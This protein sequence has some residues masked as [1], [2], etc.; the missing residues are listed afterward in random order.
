MAARSFR[1]HFVT[2]SDGRL[3]GILLRRWDRFFDKPAPSAYGRSE[4]EVYRQLEIQL[5]ELSAE[6]ESLDRYLWDETFEVR[7]ADL[8]IFPQSLV[9]KLPVIGNRRVPLRLTYVACKLPGGAYRVMLPRFGWWMLVESLEVAGEALKSAVSAA[10]LG[11][12]PRWL[13]DF[14]REGEEYLQSW[15]PDFLARGTDLAAGDQAEEGEADFPTLSAVAEELV[16]RAARRR[17]PQVVGE[18]PSA[19]RCLELCG[20]YPPPSVLLVGEPGSGKS[21]AVRQLAWLLVRRRRE[22]GQEATPRIW[23][24]SG[25]RI[26]AG[27]VYLGMWQQRCY[28][29]L[30][31][32]AHEGDY[33]YVDRLGPLVA[34]QADG[35]SIIDLLAPAILGG[36]ISLLAECTPAELEHHRRRLPALIDRFEIVRVEETDAAA[37]A[38]LLA[39]YLARQ[40]PDLEPRGDGLRLLV[41]YLDA[42]LPATRF[43]GKGFHFVDW[44]ARQEAHGDAARGTSPADPD[45][46]L[47][48]KPARARTLYPADAARLFAAYSGLPEALI[49]DER[50]LAPADIA[51]SL[52]QRVVGQP[53]ACAACA[54]VIARFKA[55]LNDPELPLGTFLFVGP[56]GVGKT[57]LAKQLTRYLFGDAGRMVRL[58]MSEYMTG[59]S[60]RRLLEVGPGL[61][62]LAQRVREQP[63]CVVLLDEIEK[64]HP[65]VFDLLLGVLG[66]GRMTDSLGRLVDF[67]TAL[68]IMTSNLGVT[69]SAPA[70]FGGR[71]REGYLGEVRRHF[72]PEFFNRIDHAVA[73]RPLGP[74][75]ILR[76]VDIVLGEAAARAGLR[77]RELGL[78]VSDAARHR[79][80]RLGFHPT[81]GA[82]PLRRAV[83]EH[84]ITPLAVRIAAEPGL[85]GVTVPV[86]VQGEPLSAAERG[87]AIELLGE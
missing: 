53:E 62:S 76:I 8:T 42:F 46:P 16:E 85:C 57:E 82:R 71:P 10:L 21:A 20:D 51:A 33:L 72:R 49:S 81:R 77:R 74:D 60:A 83:E 35:A 56:T 67:R 41:Q 24:T 23:R 47:A 54:S 87:L 5:A 73:F 27:M 80:S 38:P 12:H 28:E 52:G 11:E 2:H 59:G 6:R 9:K 14:R 75:D 48:A 65:R 79:L 31:E 63:L 55:R 68:I 1:V 17:L 45:R 7:R 19:R 58:D 13:Y 44:L 78:R 32:L 64:A 22:L 86:V 39:L 34:R 36:E 26:I 70:G 50:R 25:E 66:E 18:I 29:L 40:L 37:M 3:T 61:R 43:P 84:V 69:D 30:E 15:V 4:E